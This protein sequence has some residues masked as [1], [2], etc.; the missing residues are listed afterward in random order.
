MATPSSNLTLQNWFETTLSS[1]ISASDT[2]IPLNTVPTGVEGFLVIEPDSAT[3]REVIFFSAK[4]ASQV[5][6][7]SAAQ[8]RGQDGTTGV[9]HSS[10]ATVRMNFT[11]GYY[12]ALQS[13]ASFPA[14]ALN[15]SQVAGSDEFIFDHIAS[16]CVWSGDA[17][18]STRNASCTSG[19]V[20]LSGKRLTVAAVTARSFTA[21]KD[22]YCDLKDNG[23]GTAVWVY[24]DNTTNAAS[25]SFA[26]TGGTLRGA[27]V[28]VGASNIAAATSI[29]QGGFA[30]T[31]PVIASQVLRGF[32]S[33]GNTI[34]PKGPSSPARMQNPS[35]FRVYRSAAQ[36]TT[37]GTSKILF[38]TKL[39]D[40]GNEFDVTTNNRF[41]AKI[42][43]IY[44]FSATAQSLSLANFQLI[45]YKNGA[46]VSNGI[47]A[48]GASVNQGSIVTDKVQLAV[49]DYVEVFMIASAAVAMFTGSSGIY[50]SGSLESAS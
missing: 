39:F 43:G 1:S 9:S 26:T 6:C 16:G 21:S 2:A 32:D 7:P 10:G 12:D 3:N 50:F 36:S 22:V 24:Y 37:N 15:P 42:A 8:G 38:D 40:K 5:T 4:T 47:N 11:K 48:S 28:V 44:N 17:Y 41:V 35:M 46:A 34:Y 14:D 23:D 33:I 18:A 19:V 27:I 49:G 30:N 45:L 25:P 20:Y 29:G 31:A 13:G